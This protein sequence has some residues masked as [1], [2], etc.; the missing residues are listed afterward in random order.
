M[1]PER[2]LT[3]L[4]AHRDCGKAH[5]PLCQARGFFFT[6]S[7]IIEGVRLDL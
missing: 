1:I 5:L 7:F 2:A 3:K 6:A 4:D